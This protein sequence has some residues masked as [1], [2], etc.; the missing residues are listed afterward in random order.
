[1][2]LSITN[3]DLMG[4]ILAQIGL[5]IVLL[6][7]LYAR[8]IPAMAKAKPTNEQMQDK[9]ATSSLPAPARYAAENYNHQFEAPVLFYALCIGAMVSG[10]ASELSVTFAWAYVGLR[11]VHS[12]I[13]I[14]YNKVMH[15]FG[16]FMLSNIALIGLF[17]TILLN[18]LG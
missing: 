13:H 12:I 18:Y 10:L 6:F 3:V 8:R 4:P 1:M 5:G 14:T 7:I 2:N 16:V 17:I 15:R 11:I 9:A